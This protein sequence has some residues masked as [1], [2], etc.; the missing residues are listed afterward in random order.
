MVLKQ[1][2]ILDYELVLVEMY[3]LNQNEY[4]HKVSKIFSLNIDKK[5]S[6]ESLQ[7]HAM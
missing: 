6:I 4:E 2:L 5:L 1:H 7:Y 3:V